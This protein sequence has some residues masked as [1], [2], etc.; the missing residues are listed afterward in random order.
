[1]HVE[2]PVGGDLLLFLLPLQLPHANL[3]GFGARLSTR[4]KSRFR[5]KRR[6]SVSFKSTN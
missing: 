6:E 2:D 4:S 3:A 1:L 5:L